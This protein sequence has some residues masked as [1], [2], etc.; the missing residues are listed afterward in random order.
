MIG[1]FV[2]NF[3]RYGA[4]ITS[5]ADDQGRKGEKSKGVSD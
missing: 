1:I 2:R 5:Y 4:R 3:G